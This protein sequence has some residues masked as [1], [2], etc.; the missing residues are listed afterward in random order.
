MFRLQIWAAPSTSRSAR[1]TFRAWWTD[2]V[3]GC[4][5]AGSSS[6][7][8]AGGTSPALHPSALKFCINEGQGHDRGRCPAAAPPDSTPPPTACI[9]D[10]TNT[11]AWIWWTVWF[12]FFLLVLLSVAECC[13]V[14]GL[15]LTKQL[16][17]V[18]TA[19]NIACTAGLWGGTEPSF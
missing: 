12:E 13:R 9:A 18:S 16:F 14:Q 3:S 8:R 11:T 6:G 17:L 19:S 2:V 15:Y 1:T 7:G 5:W 10:T 4:P